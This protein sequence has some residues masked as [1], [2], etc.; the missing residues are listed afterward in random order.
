LA[1]FLQEAEQLSVEQTGCSKAKKT[2]GSVAVN[3]N[4]AVA[5]YSNFTPGIK[6]EKRIDCAV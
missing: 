4:G 1:D 3:N 5:V 2:H 6:N